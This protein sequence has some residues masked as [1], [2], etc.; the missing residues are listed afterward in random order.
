MST[1]II[2]QSLLFVF[3]DGKAIFQKFTFDANERP[4]MKSIMLRDLALKATR[5]AGITTSRKDPKAITIHIQERFI[6]DSGELASRFYSDMEITPPAAPMTS[7]EYKQEFETQLC[8][9]PIEFRG[10]LAER[11]D[12][13]HKPFEEAISVLTE[14]TDELVTALSQYAR[15]TPKDRAEEAI[16]ALQGLH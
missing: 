12:C 11:A 14:L 6:D 7:A 13:N 15:N 16:V 5:T 4:S 2:T 1:N 3:P 8:R 10:F 9:V